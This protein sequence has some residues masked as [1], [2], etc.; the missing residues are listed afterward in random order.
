[1]AVKW[2]SGSNL[3]KNLSKAMV[4]IEQLENQKVTDKTIQF[5]IDDYIRF[6]SKHIRVFPPKV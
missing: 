3:I 5:I 2:Q 6:K 1:M 4:K